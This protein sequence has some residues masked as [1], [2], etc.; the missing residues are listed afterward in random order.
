MRRLKLEGGR[1]R[2][3]GMRD[4]RYLFFFCHLSFLPVCH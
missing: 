4:E 2:E 1:K 3:R